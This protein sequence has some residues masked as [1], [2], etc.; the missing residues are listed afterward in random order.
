MICKNSVR[1]SH[2]TDA[3]AVE[4]A[5]RLARNVVQR[6]AML[7]G[8]DCEQGIRR[9]SEWFMLDES[10]LR[11]LRRRPQTLKTVSF[12]MLMNLRAAEAFLV[13]RIS[14][15]EEQAIENRRRVEELTKPPELESELV[16]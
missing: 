9:A 3:Q 12:P 1:K 2:I 15:I 16:T 11:T 10:N 5:R 6:C 4:E 13:D 8:G 7:C 14:S